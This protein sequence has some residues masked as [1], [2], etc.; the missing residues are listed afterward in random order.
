MHHENFIRHLPDW[1][2]VAIETGFRG[3][4]RFELEISNGNRSFISRGVDGL[5]AEDCLS[6]YFIEMDSF[7]SNLPCWIHSIL[8]K[9]T[10]ITGI[11]RMHIFSLEQDFG[12]SVHWTTIK[13]RCWNFAVQNNSFTK[14]ACADHYL[15]ENIFFLWTIIFPQKGTF[16]NFFLFWIFFLYWQ[17]KC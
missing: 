5:Y 8:S 16:D 6:G 2:S 10:L 1:L 9:T 12:Q 4:I 13:M 3:R 11:E 15:D 7:R 14:Y 17:M